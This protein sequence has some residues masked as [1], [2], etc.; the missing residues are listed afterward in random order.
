MPHAVYT[1]DLSRFSSLRKATVRS[2]AQA[3][4]RYERIETTLARAK[5]TQRFTERLITL[6]KD[7]TLHARRRAIAILNDADLVRRLFSEI[8]P[9]FANRPGGY[10]RIFHE[11]YRSGDGA[12]M[13]IIE[14]VELGEDLKQKSKVAKEKKP[15]SGRSE[16]PAKTSITPKESL[17]VPEIRPEKAKK[18]EEKPQKSEVEPKKGDENPKKPEGKPKGF[19][20]GLRNFFKGRPEQ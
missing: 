4:L 15:S 20:D 17:E 13:A 19:I 3:L 7:G 10:T 9:R 16:R 8:A 6:G 1:R 14:L 11:G 12:S 5:E 2:L 18:L